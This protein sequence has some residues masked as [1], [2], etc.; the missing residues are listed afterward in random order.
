VTLQGAEALAAHIHRQAGGQPVVSMVASTPINGSAPSEALGRLA[1]DWQGK[2]YACTTALDAQNY[3]FLPVDA[4]KVPATELK[5]AIA[6]TVTNMIDFSNE[7]ATIDVLSVPFNKDA[8][9][10]ART[11]YAVVARTELANEIQRYFQSAKLLL[12]VIDIPEMAQR[13]IAALLETEGR[14]I[15]LISFDAAGG[16]L[17]FTCGGELYLTRRLDI[18]AQQIL[19]ADLE[20]RRTCQERVALEI[21]R[22]LDHF[23]RQFNWVGVKQLVVAPLGDDD[24]GLVTYLADNLETQVQSLNLETILD[25]SRVPELKSLAT[26][27]KYFITLGLALRHEEK[28][29]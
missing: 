4:P 17:T 29:L 7:E 15:A 23:S 20:Q 16:L 8:P 21:Q 12:K 22:S 18:T 2:Q 28:V 1:R 19:G 26:Q 11:M 3:H 10:R 9:Q 27:Q 13:N 5:A 25:L 6:W 24:G 14:G